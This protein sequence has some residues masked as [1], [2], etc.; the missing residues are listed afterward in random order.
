MFSK[1]IVGNSMVIMFPIDFRFVYLLILLLL[2][3][4]C[5][6]PGGEIAVETEKVTT[7]RATA[8]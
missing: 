6:L 2:T 8:T 1:V 3:I 5:W 4:W 7:E